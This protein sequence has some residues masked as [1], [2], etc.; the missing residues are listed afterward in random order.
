[1]ESKFTKKLADMRKQLDHRWKQIDK[2]EEAVKGYA[3]AK[4]AWRRKYSSKE[5]ELEAIKV[6]S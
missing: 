6:S 4:A 2:F 1:M 3:D 5:G